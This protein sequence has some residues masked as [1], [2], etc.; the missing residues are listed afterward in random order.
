MGQR[1]LVRATSPVAGVGWVGG[2]YVQVSR[3]LTDIHTEPREGLTLAGWRARSLQGER[4][5]RETVRDEES[6]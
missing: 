4:A 3:T 1:V 5:D 2:A 6:M